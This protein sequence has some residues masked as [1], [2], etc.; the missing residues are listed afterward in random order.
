MADRAPPVRVAS[1]F[2]TVRDTDAAAQRVRIARDQQLSVRSASAA[3]SQQ[4]HNF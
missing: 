4:I 2:K 3:E 1:D